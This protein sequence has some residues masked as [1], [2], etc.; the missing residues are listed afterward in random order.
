[1]VNGLKR[2]WIG[3]IEAN[4][5]LTIRKGHLGLAASQLTVS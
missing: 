1:M 4:V 3:H 5:P 2:Y